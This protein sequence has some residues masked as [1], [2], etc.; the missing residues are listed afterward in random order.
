MT[1]ER[2]SFDPGS[3]IA[4][5]RRAALTGDTLVDGGPS[6]ELP[7][8]RIVGGDYVIARRLLRCDVGILYEV[9][10][11]STRRLRTL[12]VLDRKHPSC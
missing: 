12:K 8:G 6:L 11:Q 5:R 9:E 4:P 7:V 10:Q 3:T 1:R 2:P